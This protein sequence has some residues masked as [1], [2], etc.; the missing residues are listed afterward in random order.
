MDTYYGKGYQGKF[1][2]KRTR[3]P[4]PLPR[5]PRGSEGETKYYDAA[6]SYVLSTGAAGNWTGTEID[7]NTPSSL[8]TLFDPILGTDIT[9]RIGRRVMVKGMKINLDVNVA[10]LAGTNLGGRDP[11]VIRVI[12]YMDKQ[13][14]AAQSLGSQLMAPAALQG[15]N[16]EQHFQSLANLGRFKVLWDQRF[17]I[18]DPNVGST[19]AA[20]TYDI[21]GIVVIRKMRLKFKRGIIVNFNATNGGTVADIVDNSFHIIACASSISMGP[22]LSYVVRTSYKDV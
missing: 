9:N 8:L 1:V 21:N 19:Q 12:V 5:L 16:A 4:P 14:N 18:E 6:G 10:A 3:A 22:V 15:A 2:K 11:A 20:D 13:T 17:V 7:P